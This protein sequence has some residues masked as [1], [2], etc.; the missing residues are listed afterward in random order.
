MLVYI[1]EETVTVQKILKEEHIQLL[2]K[3]KVLLDLD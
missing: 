2:C 1:I 3:E